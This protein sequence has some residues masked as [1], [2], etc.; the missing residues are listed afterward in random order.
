MR[1]G[2][3]RWDGR[4]L[5]RGRR[6]VRALQAAPG[7]ELV[8]R[9]RLESEAHGTRPV[10]AHSPRSPSL[11]FLAATPMEKLREAF[12]FSVFICKALEFLECVTNSPG[13]PQPVRKRNSQVQV[14]CTE[15]HALC[16]VSLPLP[17]YTRGKTAW[18]TTALTNVSSGSPSATQTCQD[19]GHLL[20]V[21]PF[22]VTRGKGPW[23]EGLGQSMASS[24]HPGCYPWVRPEQGRVLG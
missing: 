18:F 13:V 21:K 22:S 4:C 23:R 1:T 11:S 16:P 8:S 15:L 20:R 9:L 17:L 7:L 6:S 12:S 3:L 5:A 24:V 10:P 2:S 19:P 14:F